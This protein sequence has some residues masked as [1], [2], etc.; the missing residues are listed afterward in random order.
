AA[1]ALREALANEAKA[2][3]VENHT[4]PSWTL[5]DGSRV[6]V[7]TTSGGPVVTDWDAFIDWARQEYPGEMIERTVVEFRNPNFRK[8]VIAELTEACFEHSRDLP[9][10]LGLAPKGEYRSTSITIAPETKERMAASARQ[11]VL[12]G[13]TMPE[14]EARQA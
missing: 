9:P 8:R 12:A 14:L 2:E 4:A 1:A 10:F 6:V 7:S 13:E 11:Y 3:L 5:P